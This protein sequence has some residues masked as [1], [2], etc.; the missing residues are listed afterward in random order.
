VDF[1]P[2][3]EYDRL[4]RLLGVNHEPAGC[5]D[6]SS[7]ADPMTLPPNFRPGTKAQF[8]VALSLGAS[9]WLLTVGFAIVGY[10]EQVSWEQSVVVQKESLCFAY[11]F[12]VAGT[13][14]GVA[15]SA[16]SGQRR[17]AMGSGAISL[18]LLAGS[19]PI[20]RWLIFP[21][22]SPNITWGQD[23]WHSALGC[24]EVG[25]LLGGFVGL[26]ISGLV[27]ASVPLE[28]RLKTWQFG[29]MIAGAIALLGMWVLPAALP[30]LSD[31]VILYAGVHY[32]YLYDEALRGAGI[33]AGTGS[34]A[35]AIVLGSIARWHGAK[36]GHCSMIIPRIG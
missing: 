15:A 16:T 35:G 23:V 2:D 32:R 12:A 11:A 3:R 26:I 33:G 18:I 4:V 13:I 24:I 28:R 6:L 21:A 17:W 9:A 25:S 27:L 34:L 19:I 36:D 30:H 7:G 29:L 10:S 14:T 20:L 31:L 5:H 22:T 8:L 1:R